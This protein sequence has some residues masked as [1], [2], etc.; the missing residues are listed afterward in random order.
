MQRNSKLGAEVL[1]GA[2]IL[3]IAI[4]FLYFAPY[5]ALL[6]RHLETKAFAEV[7]VRSISRLAQATDNTSIVYYDDTHTMRIVA[8]DGR[9]VNGIVC[10]DDLRKVIQ[11][12]KIAG[13]FLIMYAGD[14]NRGA[15]ID[16][17]DIFRDKEFEKRI[18]AVLP[19]KGVVGSK[20]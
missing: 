19:E 8:P 9:Q 20:Y 3:A 18:I 5:L 12:H 10:I 7:G 17:Q 15:G 14:R 13:P 1:W 6:R 2:A 16:S 4:A 11:L